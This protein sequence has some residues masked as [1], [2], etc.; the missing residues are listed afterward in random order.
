MDKKS[1]RALMLILTTFTYLLLGAAVFD[2]LESE[3]ERYVREEIAFVRERLQRKYNFTS[4]GN[5]P[6]KP[7][8][9]TRQ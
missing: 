5:D 1:S 2:M 6:V 4:N 7:S 8:L 3:T 9:Y